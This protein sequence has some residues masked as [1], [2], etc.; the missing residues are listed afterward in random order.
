MI[1]STI[2]G[3]YKVIVTE[4]KPLD[5]IE[6]YLKEEE[7]IFILS[8]DGC[9]EVCKAGGEAEAIKM[10][11]WIKSIGKK[12]VGLLV[13]DFL[14]N[15][16]LVQTRLSRHWE[17]IEKCDSFLV[18]SCGIGVQAVSKVVRKIVHPAC[19]TI[20]LEGIQGLWPSEERCMECGDCH[21]DFTGGIC[22]ISNCSKGLLNGPCGGAIEGKCEVDRRRDC[23]WIKIYER[24]L[25]I[26]KLD[27]MRG[28]RKS[29]DF[30]KMVA[31][32][33]LRADQKFDIEK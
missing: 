7:G 2:G 9:A 25:R 16:L 33:E 23:G 27:K 8:C 30:S 21:L 5:E 20:S 19:N 26:G 14:C 18:M 11:N 1:P 6:G 4:I 3:Y 17:E 24:L 31:S 12:S 22:P 10:E 13:V 15:R 28:I 32:P 29:S